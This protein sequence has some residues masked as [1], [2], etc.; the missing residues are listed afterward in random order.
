[1]KVVILPLPLLKERVMREEQ[2]EVTELRV[3]PLRWCWILENVHRQVEQSAPWL[4]V[5]VRRYR[6][7]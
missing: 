2:P 5:H 7:S 4:V 6:M 3:M 1:M